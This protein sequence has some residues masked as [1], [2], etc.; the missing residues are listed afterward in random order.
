MLR[1]DIA[2]GLLVKSRSQVDALADLESEGVEKTA[3]NLMG[4]VKS[5]F[6]L[7]PGAGKVMGAEA[8]EQAAKGLSR[9]GNYTMGIGAGAGMIGGAIAGGPDN[10]LG[11]AIQGGMIGLTPGLLLK[12][13]AKA[14]N[15]TPAKEISAVSKSG[16][17]ASPT[18]N[19]PTAGS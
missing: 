4:L 9:A 14:L 1:N 6:G 3:F 13:R 19:N 2:K 7:V 11:G 8:A 17:P 15:P 5:T 16:G 10:R 18:A 12:G